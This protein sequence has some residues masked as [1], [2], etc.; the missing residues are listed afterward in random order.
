[1]LDDSKSHDIPAE[2]ACAKISGRGQW[3]VLKD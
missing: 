2:Q 3:I 1:M